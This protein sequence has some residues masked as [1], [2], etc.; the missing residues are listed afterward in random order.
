[1]NKNIKKLNEIENDLRELVINTATEGKWKEWS[2]RMQEGGMFNF[3]E[4]MLKDTG[5]ENVNYISS[6]IDEV[7]KVK[8]EIKNALQ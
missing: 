4:E 8:D 2:G 1:M 5:D 3:T 7:I 6:L